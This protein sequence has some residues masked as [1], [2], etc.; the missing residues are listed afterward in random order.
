M[1]CQ[2]SISHAQFC[3]ILIPRVLCPCYLLLSLCVDVADQLTSLVN[4]LNDICYSICH[5]GSGAFLDNRMADTQC[6][7]VQNTA[8]WCLAFLPYWW[9]FL[10]C[11]RKYRDNPPANRR[12]L[13]N[14]GKYA[15]SMFTTLF[16]L[17]YRNVSPNFLVPWICVA[18]LTTLYT[19]TWDVVCDWG[20]V[21]FEGHGRWP[22]VLRRKLLLKSSGPYY[23]ALVSNLLLRVSWVFT[24]SPSRFGINLNKDI[25]NSIVW[26]LEILRRNQ[27]N[28]YRLENEHLTNCENYRV[29]NIVPLKMDGAVLLGNTA[30]QAEKIAAAEE[31][32]FQR[33]TGGGGGAG[34]AAVD[35]DALVVE[36]SRER[37][38]RMKEHARK[39]SR[40]IELQSRIMSTDDLQPSS[41]TG[42]D[43][44][45]PLDPSRRRDRDNPTVCSMLTAPD[46]RV[47]D[48]DRHDNPDMHEATFRSG[49]GS[50]K[51]SF[52]DAM[53]TAGAPQPDWTVHLDETAVVGDSLKQKLSPSV[54][55]LA[56]QHDAAL[57]QAATA[58]QQQQQ[59][60]QPSEVSPD[61]I[62]NRPY[63]GVGVDS[64][65]S[66]V[67]PYV[68]PNVQ[69]ALALQEQEQAVIHARRQSLS[70]ASAAG[71]H[72]PSRSSFLGHPQHHPVPMM[73]AASSMQLG[74]VHGGIMHSRFPSAVSPRHFQATTL[75]PA[76]A[77]GLL[78]RQFSDPMMTDNIARRAATTARKSARRTADQQLYGTGTGVS[79]SGATPSSVPYLPSTPPA[80]VP[81][82]S[83]AAGQD[84]VR[85]GMPDRNLTTS[86]LHRSRKLP[87]SDDVSTGDDW[88]MHTGA[89]GRDAADEAMLPS[90]TREAVGSQSAVVAQ[91][92]R[93]AT[94]AAGQAGAADGVLSPTGRHAH[95]RDAEAREE[96]RRNEENAA[97]D[98]F[99]RV[100]ARRRA[101]HQLSA[102]ALAHN[103]MASIVATTT[104]ADNSG[105]PAR[106]RSN[107]LSV[108]SFPMGYAS[109]GNILQSMPQ[110]TRRVGA[111]GSARRPSQQ[112]PSSPNLYASSRGG[113]PSMFQRRATASNLTSRNGSASPLNR[114]AGPSPQRMQPAPTS[115]ATS[116]SAPV[117]AVIPAAA[118]S[119]PASVAAP[120]PTAS[121][122][123]AP[124]HVATADAPPAVPPASAPPASGAVA[125]VV[126]AGSAPAASPAAAAAS[127]G[128]APPATESA[129]TPPSAL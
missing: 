48:P 112:L 87:R 101:M 19:Y 70:G 121:G 103:A 84:E 56:E 91:A 76:S 54:S 6:T 93:A 63:G 110:Q 24:I 125:S 2:A 104:G 119:G 65:L 118:A 108:S 12:Q 95:L 126:A 20:F 22:S 16:A 14:S 13:V 90:F 72:Q 68:N 77:G 113:D 111:I 9:R 85:P 124:V 37:A 116:A 27:W 3:L 107:S 45:L 114:P 33:G 71:S 97:D 32:K 120:A 74:G 106:N 89:F 100:L 40:E 8:V 4:V 96:A 50:R 49:S 11:L 60:P 62:V 30:E 36:T 122:S 73:H 59:W 7:D 1:R 23:F 5:L 21:Q 38:A 105:D 57:E 98:L 58:A 115:P 129:P 117:P 61:S 55:D 127:P 75:A 64:T 43:E 79:P 42:A 17:L 99:D 46:A 69:H 28:V 52:A 31:D 128:F 39:R 66:P 35:P 82:G 47:L 29:V 44:S 25:F 86:V 88:L 78:Q 67:Q 83:E 123:A 34:E 81:T 41:P 109:S 94:I 102:P 18:T 92:Q 51:G 26:A 80:P 53:D 10:Q 15:A